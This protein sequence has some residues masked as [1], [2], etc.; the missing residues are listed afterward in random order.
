MVI[1]LIACV[2]A[3]S[4]A[5]AVAKPH[6][7]IKVKTKVSVDYAPGVP[8]GT[9]DPYNPYNPYNPTG[10][11]ASFSGTVQGRNGCRKARTVKLTGQGKVLS[12]NNGDYS[13]IMP[14]ASAP[15]GEYQVTVKKKRVKRGKQ[16]ITCKAATRAITLVSATRR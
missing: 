16:R 2:A 5:V 10:D 6:K 8:A 11:K 4:V 1:A 9:F 12:S 15:P 7:V 14:A 13:F 3:G